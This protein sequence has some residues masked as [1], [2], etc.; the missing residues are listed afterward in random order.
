MV[1]FCAEGNFAEA[2][3][4]EENN[5]SDEKDVENAERKSRTRDYVWD[6]EN[7]GANYCPC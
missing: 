6:S 4:Y 2:E 7:S 5:C 3:S 1:F